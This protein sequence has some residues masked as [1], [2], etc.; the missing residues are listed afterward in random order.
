MTL[1]GQWTGTYVAQ[2]PG[3]MIVDID[4]SDGQYLANVYAN[5]DD[6]TIPATFSHI[7]VPAGTNPFHI[8]HV[9]V[10]PV[11][12]DT[13]EADY[14]GKVAATCPNVVFATS[15]AVTGTWN[16][17]TLTVNWTTNLGVR[18]SAALQRSRSTAPSDYI[19]TEVT[20][21][22]FKRNVAAI[23]GSRFLF[24]G[25]RERVRLRTAFHRTGRA[26]LLRFTT[27]DLP[28]L[29]RY[30]SARTRHVFDMQKPDEFGAF[31]N[32]VQHHG[33]PT[34]LLDWTYSPYVA[35][36]FAYR[37]VT[38]QQIAEATPKDK[39]RVFAF[40]QKLWRTT[41]N[42]RVFLFASREHFSLLDPLA[43]ENERMIPQQA[44]MSVT[45]VDDI[46]TY[47]R[48]CECNTG[49]AFLTMYDLPLADRNLVMR[50][51][52]YM[53]IT[54]GSLFPGID[55]ACEELRERFFRS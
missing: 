23:E 42:Q 21:D 45:N 16:A 18:G 43:I 49:K 53:G 22:A 26:N 28:T 12:K 10:Y 20:W 51:L 6:R 46:E 30:L 8:A 39:V 2:A 4:P 7:V 47:I 37:N 52:S 40:D 9:A 36:F 41:Y 3:W 15:A 19:P 34:P 48:Q 31:L 5:P 50:E 25:Q 14:T 55:G 54:A 29:H 33:Y 24:R 32:L 11:N 27:E 1:N 17:Q 44:A 38:K 35:A 13:G